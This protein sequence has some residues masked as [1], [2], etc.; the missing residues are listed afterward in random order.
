MEVTCTISSGSGGDESNRS[1]FQFG[2]VGVDD[3]ACVIA[4]RVPGD[5]TLR[6][7]P[8]DSPNQ[9]RQQG[10][11]QSHFYMHREYGAPIPEECNRFS[12]SARADAGSENAAAMT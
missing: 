7:T 9:D 1:N 4:P 6:L 10:R 3:T 8:P 11:L 12:S 5:A 2:I